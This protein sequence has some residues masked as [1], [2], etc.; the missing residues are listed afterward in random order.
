MIINKYH[1][2]HINIIIT[3]AVLDPNDMLFVKALESAYT[4]L[5]IGGG[6]A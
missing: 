1:Y 3:C 6:G 2:Y 4:T 5:S